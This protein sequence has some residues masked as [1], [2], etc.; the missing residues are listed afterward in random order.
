MSLIAKVTAKKWGAVMCA[1][2]MV[3]TIAQTAISNDNDVP[4]AVAGEDVFVDIGVTIAFDGTESLDPDGEIVNYTWNFQDCMAYGATQVH[5]FD[6]AGVY[7]VNLLVRDNY[8]DVGFDNLKVVVKNMPPIAVAEMNSSASFT[9]GNVTVIYEDI[10]L[11]FNGS[12]STDNCTDISSLQY[13][14]DFGDGTTANASVVNHSYSK[15]GIYKAILMVT[16]GDGA[17]GMDNVTVNVTNF[18]PI[19]IAGQD[20]EI[21]KDGRDAV[22]WFDGRCSIDTPSDFPLLTYHWDFGDGTSLY[23]ASVKHIYHEEGSYEVNLT[24]TDDDGAS[25]YDIIHVNITSS[26]PIAEAGPNHVVYTNVPVTFDGT[27]SYDPDGFIVSYTWDFGDG[28]SASGEIV[29]HSYVDDG[30]Y[31]VTLTVID[32]S[33]VAGNDTCTVTV[34]NRPPEASMNIVP[35]TYI[36]IAPEAEIKVYQVEVTEKM[37]NE[38]VEYWK[39]FTN[40]TINFDASNSFDT[41]TNLD[42]D[43]PYLTYD[44]NF[45]DGNTGTGVNPS[46]SYEG[47]GTYTVT[48]TVTDDDY[49]TDTDSYEIVV[50]NRPPV[51]SMVINNGDCWGGLEGWDDWPDGCPPGD[52]DGVIY[53]DGSNSTDLDGTVVNYTWDFGD[54]TFG[55][56]V[57]VNHTYPHDF[58]D[59]E[60]YKVVLTVTDNDGD[61]DT[62]TKVIITGHGY[63]FWYFEEH[64]IEWPYCHD[65]ND[66]HHWRCGIGWWHYHHHG[67]S[68][69]WW[70]HHY[71]DKKLCP[72][73]EEIDLEIF[74]NDTIRMTP[75]GSWDYDGTIISYDWELNGN[76]IG[77]T[78]EIDIT[79][80][81]SGEHTVTLTVTD[82]YGSTSSTSILLRVYDDRPVANMSISADSGSSW[83]GQHGHHHHGW[84]HGSSWD[85]V[86]TFNASTSYDVSGTIENYTWNFGDG[87]YG[88]DVVMEH[89]YIDHGLYIVSLTVTDDEGLNDTQTAVLIVGH[90]WYYWQVIDCESKWR[91]WMGWYRGCYWGHWHGGGF[92]WH[93]GIDWFDE[94]GMEFFPFVPIVFDASDSFDRDGMIVNY[95]WDFG[96]GHYS[97]A[98]TTAHAYQ[99][100]GFYNVTLTVTDEYGATD[101][102]RF[103]VHII[104]GPEN[105]FD[106]VADAGPDQ[107]VYEDDPVTFDG[108][109]SSDDGYIASYHWD[110]GDG[111]NS[112]G[113]VVTHSYP[114]SGLYVVTLTVTDNTGNTDTDTMNVTVVNFVPIAD[115][116]SDQIVN[117]DDTVYFSGSAV[118]TP[119]D[120]PTL[121]YSW[122]FN[123]LDGIQ[124]D[125]YGTNP[126]HVY[127][128][129]GTYTVTLTVTDDDGDVGTDTMFV[130]VNNVPPT[131]Y[132]GEDQTTFE[133]TVIFFNG[134]GDDT[135]SDLETLT[136]TWDFNDGT[137][138]DGTNVSHIFTQSGVY[139]IRLIVTDDDG[140][141][142]FEELEVTVQNIPP[143]ADAGLNLTGN[144][145]G[146]ITF[147]ASGSN[148]TISDKDGL[149]YFWDFGDNSTG[150][151]I[152][153]THVYRESGEYTATL[154]VVDDDG[155]NST[156]TTIVTVMNVPPTAYIGTDLNLFNGIVNFSF[157]GTGTDT[158]SDIESLTYAWN[159]GG[160]DHDEVD[161]IGK[162]VT[163]AYEEDGEYIVTL[164]VTDDDGATATHSI[165]VTVRMDSD[166]DGLPD[167]WEIMYDL[168]YLPPDGASGDNG[169]VG[170]PDGDI[171]V[172]LEEYYYGLIPVDDDTDD[173]GILDG[174]EDANRNGIV[175]AGETDPLNH[176]TDGDGLN[177]GLEIGLNVAQG[178][179]TAAFWQNDW[180]SANVTDPLDADTDDDGITDGNEDCLP[181]NGMVDAGE[182]DPAKWDTDEDYLPDGL[183]IGLTE[184]QHEDTDINDFIADT[185]PTTKTDPT[186]SDC[187]GDG[188]L[189]GIEDINHNGYVD[190][191]EPDPNDW[192]SEDDGL[193]DG[194]GNTVNVLTL[195]EIFNSAENTKT[196][197]LWINGTTL[198]HVGYAVPDTGYWEIAGED[199]TILDETVAVAFFLKKMPITIITA[200]SEVSY[201]WIP[202]AE[203]DIS[204]DVGTSLTLK[205]TCEKVNY[206]F[207]D[208]DPAIT[209]ADNDGFEDFAE[210]MYLSGRMRDFR[211]NNTDNDSV[212]KTLLDGTTIDNNLVDPD[213]DGDGLLDGYEWAYGSDMLRQDTEYDGIGDY[214]EFVEGTNPID[215]DTDWDGLTD[216]EELRL[217]DD[218]LLTSPIEPDT[219]GDYLYDGWNDANH[220]LVYDDGTEDWGEVGDIANG[221]VGGYG[222]NPTLEDTDFDELKDGEEVDFWQEVYDITSATSSLTNA[223]WNSDSDDDGTIN[224]LDPDSD[225]DGINDGPE[226]AMWESYEGIVYP[227]WN[228]NSDESYTNDKKINIIDSDSDQ[229][230]LEDGAEMLTYLTRADKW[231][232]DEDGIWS[233]ILWHRT[234]SRDV[235]NDYIEVNYWLA[236]GKTDTEAGTNACNDDT[237]DDGLMDGWEYY[238]SIDPDSDIGDDGA[239]GDPDH[240]GLTNAQEYITRYNLFPNNH[241]TDGDNLY[242]GW[243]DTDQDTIYDSGEIWGEVGDPDTGYSG[244]YA[245][246]SN[247]WDS[248]DD[249]FGNSVVFYDGD[250][251]AYWEDHGYSSTQAGIKAKDD[252]VDNDGMEDGWE[253]YY[254]KQHTPPYLNPDAAS[255]ADVDSDGDGLKNLE[256]HD[257]WDV[258]VD[259]QGESVFHVQSNPNEVNADN[260]ELNDKQEKEYGSTL[261][262]S[263]VYGT[264]PWDD[265]TDD[266]TIKDGKSDEPNG[267]DPDTDG[268]GLRDDYERDTTYPAGDSGMTKT[269]NIDPDTDG[270]G[271][272][273][274]WVDTNKDLDWDTGESWGDVGDPDDLFNGGYGTSPVKWDHDNDGAADGY[275]KVIRGTYR[276][277]ELTAGTSQFDPDHDGDGLKDGYELTT[278]YYGYLK[279]SPTDPDSDDD[280]VP[281][282]LLYD[283]WNDANNNLVY[284]AGEAWGEI[285]NPEASGAG[286]FGTCPV[287]EDTDFDNINDGPEIAYW[288]DLGYTDT[289][290]GQKSNTKHSDDDNWVD[291]DEILIYY[292]RP[293]LTSTDTDGVPDDE[294]VDPLIDLEVTVEI[295]EILALDPVDGG[296]AD[297]FVATYIAGHLFGSFP[298]TDID[299]TPS[300]TDA[301]TGNNWDDDDHKTPAEIGNRFTFT[302]DV[303]DEI[304]YY[305]AD[306]VQIEIYL[307]DDDYNWLLPGADDFCDISE[308][309][310]YV[311]LFYDLKTGIWCGDDGVDDNNGYGHVSG[312]E[313]GSTNTDQDDCE[314]WFDV[315]QNGADTDGLT[316]WNE[317]H[318][319]FT[320]PTDWD[321][322]GD[323]LSDKEA[324]YT[325]GLDPFVWNDP[326]GDADGDTIANLWE[327]SVL[328]TNPVNDDTDG[329]HIRDDR[330][331]QPLR[332][333]RRFAF[334]FEVHD[335][336]GDGSDLSTTE[337]INVAN[338]LGDIDFDH[339]Y[340]VSDNDYTGDIDFEGTYAYYDDIWWKGI[341]EDTTDYFKSCTLD[342]W[343]KK[344]GEDI[345]IVYMTSHGS[346]TFG[347]YEFILSW[348]VFVIYEDVIHDELEDDM[349]DALDLIWLSTCHSA[350]SFDEWGAGDDLIIIG[351][352]DLN[353]A[354]SGKWDAAYDGRNVGGVWIDGFA[355]WNNASPVEVAFQ[356]ADDRETNHDLEIE[357]NYTGSLYLV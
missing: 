97:Y 75:K 332:Y 116:G 35:K 156:A 151:G 234:Y 173:D 91:H 80:T 229:E 269:S 20:L 179:D 169:A 299:N 357:D 12:K 106:P 259:R 288:Q 154:T 233:Y 65:W 69:V 84:H 162:D 72:C 64:W 123:E 2:V 118:D 287:V 191:N 27:G 127:T 160:G 109:A 157:N 62:D 354:G 341:F 303:S 220:N 186:D 19:A 226:K 159:F 90:H 223:N 272:Y 38:Y 3:L 244:G 88:Y 164:T 82:D 237:D 300:W 8:G 267:L 286:G 37:E 56:G 281:G 196:V 122:D 337:G 285:G 340:L 202:D 236:Q 206:T 113:M 50:S 213:S 100:K 224:L 222:T 351:N 193:A 170:D 135:P 108:S 73:H 338:S 39:I 215:P 158:N 278:E 296:E 319:Y 24:V 18:E 149:M 119:S 197:S 304:G 51:A 260:D 231:D 15:S 141:R 284:D 248:D 142:G 306:E 297:F 182:T 1:T 45:G 7:L 274:G 107:T 261:S 239:A 76:L 251:V 320:D 95:T 323:A 41:D 145:D 161:E 6:T 44:W 258:Y 180:D 138:A 216:Y 235:F 54:G 201:N 21:I 178:D 311:F 163:Y 356:C 302:A 301:N 104:F 292:T 49:A 221:F 152:Y 353:D 144:E 342:T 32:D 89:E 184:P 232:T 318:D 349:G 124:D 294:D 225:N 241:D 344:N 355:D 198:P 10:P 131:A 102:D 352:S 307:Y 246:Y 137:T 125:A 177:D 270:D 59:C 13:Y 86:L 245:T 317:V 87:T 218:G 110:F 167:Y 293:D 308:T 327:I 14:W 115:A 11:T 254:A 143:I 336:L 26:L 94:D 128:L 5:A 93:G 295:Q 334:I 174:N 133:D 42:D 268:D 279:T 256:E 331:K 52:W 250:E 46:H 139:H 148:D 271:L 240:D 74:V 181:M 253:V 347:F 130:T 168:D 189:D 33:G 176:D 103:M 192:D 99:Y 257:G 70:H 217:A 282:Q 207:A 315:Y 290:A 165:N 280:G 126:S 243:K 211:T 129:T 47:D 291:G 321:T 275:N 146:I 136:Y 63:F 219:D 9:D 134:T 98:K 312:E 309:G 147:N 34:M 203:G 313:D 310:K 58:W 273:D 333:N 209:D 262:P 249:A 266:D 199:T 28:E 263:T 55:Y 77:Q 183:E 187:D 85:G 350:D 200:M 132:A 345:A 30:E 185:D 175:D 194:S 150:R 172:N 79:F 212:S 22:V 329:D 326:M 335:F 314:L 66:R 78:K 255:D 83:S 112:D 252:D 31:L 298:N 40:E 227:G 36:D 190:S 277:G 214:E 105:D 265:D 210:A 322:D 247:D 71:R 343:Q 230:G 204:I 195:K 208:P 53:F 348:L 328:G 205:F 114:L 228:Q 166:E 67:H 48:L 330:D 25:T 17:S 92:G 111:N 16:D 155:A 171:L 264:D 61:T 57:K 316:W 325:P 81:E 117:E 339:V 283:G 60:I 346:S 121:N 324:L 238:Y 289:Q 276:Y 43:I 29:T 68:W 23:G 101:T 242:D 305:V 188:L 96:D 140:A 153:A 4:I 120:E